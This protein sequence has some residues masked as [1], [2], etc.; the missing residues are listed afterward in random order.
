M[1]IVAGKHLRKIGEEDKA[2]SQFKIAQKV[3][4]AFQEDFVETK[5]FDSTV[6]EYTREQREEIET[7][8]AE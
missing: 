2:V 6:Y 7:L 8:L 4:D 1:L 5:W 3:M